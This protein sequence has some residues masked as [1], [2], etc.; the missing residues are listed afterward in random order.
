MIKAKR[1]KDVLVFSKRSYFCSN[2]M[3]NFDELKIFC[4]TT[5]EDMYE[6]GGFI[7]H[8]FN[9]EKIERL[10]K[11]FT[12]VAVD[13]LEEGTLPRKLYQVTLRKER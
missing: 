7:V 11:G 1:V 2:C 9:R 10:A 8:F 13:E 5:G 12:L 3:I 6:V 4:N